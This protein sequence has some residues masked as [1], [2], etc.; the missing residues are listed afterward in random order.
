MCAVAAG[1]NYAS[2]LC[3][4]IEALD[5]ESLWS[6]IDSEMH[7]LVVLIHIRRL[8]TH[9]IQINPVSLNTK[10]QEEKDTKQAASSNTQ[11][12]ITPYYYYAYN[13]HTETVI[14]TLYI[15]YLKACLSNNYKHACTL[16]TII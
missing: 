12:I 1:V 11:H 13:K 6:A 4:L 15:R 5:E 3:H 8:Q 10:G 9:A 16:S 2:V 14:H 7:R